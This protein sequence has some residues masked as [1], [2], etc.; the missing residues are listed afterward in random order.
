MALFD[1]LLRSVPPL[2]TALRLPA[3]RTTSRRCIRRR[4]PPRGGT[5]TVI[6]PPTPP[7]SPSASSSLTGVVLRVAQFL[8][9]RSLW[10]D[11]ALLA[12]NLVGRP[13]TD[14][15]G[16]LTSGRPP[17]SVPR[18]DVARVL[19]RRR[20]RARP[21]ADPSLAL[22]LATVLFAV[23]ARNFSL[24]VG[25]RR[26]PRVR[27]A[28]ALVYDAAELKPYSS[29][30]LVTVVLVIIGR[31]VTGEPSPGGRS[32]TGPPASW[33]SSARFRRCSSRPDHRRSDR[34]ASRR[35]VELAAGDLRRGDLE[36]RDGHTRPV[37]NCHAP[38]R[39]VRRS[40]AG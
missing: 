32:C 7:A 30:V 38:T 28:D 20:L 26:H 29:D 4:N 1:V 19:G 6:R 37:R 35:R 18:R 31:H 15:V 14:V 10:H 8:S 2:V 11:E 36:R 9:G 22:V 13:F 34:Q 24:V 17:R 12:L 21:P 40:A 25:G 27:V 23:L 33:P 5:R 16:E 39:S 3:G